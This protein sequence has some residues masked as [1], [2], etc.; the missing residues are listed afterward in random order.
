MILSN[1]KDRVCLED[2][3]LKLD[4]LLTSI[5]VD[6]L[7]AT[8]YFETLWFL[9]QDWGCSQLLM[10]AEC[11]FLHVLVELFQNNTQ[12]KQQQ[13]AINWTLS[14]LNILM[15]F[16][17]YMSDEIDFFLGSRCLNFTPE[18]ESKRPR[19]ALKTTVRPINR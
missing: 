14:S 19:T 17:T 8:S 11:L 4:V 9:L 13:K 12:I 6:F 18:E 10:W 3:L 5:P 1:I 16:R 2:N 7:K 15:K